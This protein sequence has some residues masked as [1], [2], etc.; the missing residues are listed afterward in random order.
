VSLD[1]KW[2]GIQG[3]QA[4]EAIQFDP[5]IRAESTIRVR[6]RNDYILR[7]MYDGMNSVQG[8]AAGDRDSSGSYRAFAVGSY[9]GWRARPPYLP[10][11]SNRNPEEKQNLNAGESGKN[12]SGSRARNCF[13]SSALANQQEDARA[14]HRDC[15]A[16]LLRR[17]RGDVPGARERPELKR[18]GQ[19]RVPRRDWAG[20]VSGKLIP[21]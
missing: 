18:D 7:S 10:G 21:R 2:H 9:F 15:L 19:P 8:G 17:Q 12:L 5:G 11:R 6:R 4:S 16:R 13:A 3:Q 1:C 14:G 20:R